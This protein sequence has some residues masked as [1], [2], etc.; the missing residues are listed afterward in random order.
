MMPKKRSK[1]ENKENF[2]QEK[3]DS[4]KAKKQI[5]SIQMIRIWI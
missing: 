1:L 4:W 3:N 5:S 2:S